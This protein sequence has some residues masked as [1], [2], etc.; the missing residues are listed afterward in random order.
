MK[1]ASL[2]PL[3]TLLAALSAPDALAQH[4]R[5]GGEPG[6]HGARERPAT[7]A[8]STRTLAGP[9]Q[10]WLHAGGG[11]LGS[12]KEVRSRYGAGLDAGLSGDRR[13]ADRLALRA[14]IDFH[15]L[16]SSRPNYI[17]VNGIAYGTNADYGH[18]WFGS[19]QG[20]LSARP[21]RHLWLEGAAGGGYFENGFPGDQTY[22]DGATGEIRRFNGSSGWG[23]AWSAAARYEFQPNVRDRLLA[24]F[25]FSSMDRGGTTLN[26]MA[27]RLGYRAF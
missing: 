25:Q 11:R 2:L 18:G 24:E 4:G 6:Y 10:I 5:P 14:R 15:D 9:W 23:T 21:W 27:L 19:A 20:C 1:H 26:F 17:F 7:H 12:P 13:F 8:D 3:V 22:V 16:P